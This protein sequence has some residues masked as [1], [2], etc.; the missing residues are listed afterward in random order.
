MTDLAKTVKTEGE[1]VKAKT[2]SKTELIEPIDFSFK[3]LMVFE[4]F[5]NFCI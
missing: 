1:T 5:L 4:G 3:D 2:S